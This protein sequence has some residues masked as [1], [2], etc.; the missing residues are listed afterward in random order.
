MLF[1]CGDS[2]YIAHEYIDQFEAS[3]KEMLHCGLTMVFNSKVARPCDK[4]T[5]IIKLE[6]TLLV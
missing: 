2:F 1:K 3:L 5:G 4:I 6:A